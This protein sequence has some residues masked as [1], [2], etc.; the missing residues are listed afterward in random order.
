[1]KLLTGRDVAD[2]IK[3]RHVST[4]RGLDVRPPLALIRSKDNEAGDKYLK[5]KRKYG[6]DI[7]AAVD[8]Y[9]ETSETILDRIHTLAKDDSVTGIIIQLPLTDL[10]IT[11]KAL[12]AI[13]LEKDIDGLA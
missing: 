3:E 6:E 10:S 2:Y 7:G 11:D 5:M 9:V 12:A 13:P 1:M 8:L 4:I